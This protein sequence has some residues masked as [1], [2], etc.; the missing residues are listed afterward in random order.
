MVC[1]Y[2]Y[3][4]LESPPSIATGIIGPPEASD[5]TDLDA[6]PQSQYFY[7]GSILWHLASSQFYIYE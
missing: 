3:V 4:V 6:R 5:P 1:V 7:H 2:V